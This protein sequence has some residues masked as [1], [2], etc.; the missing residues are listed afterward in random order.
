M[1]YKV[2]DKVKVKSLDWYNANKDDHGMVRTS[3]GAIGFTESM[4][5][6]CDTVVT[7][8]HVNSDTY[9]IEEDIQPGFA[10]GWYWTDDMFEGLVNKSIDLDK[11]C[12]DV[13]DYPNADQVDILLSDKF[14]VEIMHE[15]KIVLVRKKSLYPDNFDD[16]FELVYGKT[17]YPGVSVTIGDLI[18]EQLENKMHELTKL[19]ICR[20]AYWKLY[21]EQLGV[22]GMWEPAD[23]VMVY[24]I[25]RHDGK[26]VR[27][28]L[29]GLKYT[30]EFPTEEM[31]DEFK[32]NF[33][34]Q[35]E[36]CKEFI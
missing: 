18:D 14:E 22:D 26:L 17:N 12:V 34:K 31:R 36:I 33:E 35:F 9:F 2:G 3:V 13:N 27:G 20:N 4:V 5:D 25:S 7:I 21:N 28:Y 8:K 1:K 29:Y 16:C 24:N 23:N 19:I 11:I 15:N 6:F 30:F 32:K 10:S